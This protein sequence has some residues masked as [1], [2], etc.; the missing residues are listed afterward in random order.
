[1]RRRVVLG[2]EVDD[3]GAFDAGEFVPAEVGDLAAGRGGVEAGGD[4]EQAVDL[5]EAVGDDGGL[6]DEAEFAV[7]GLDP[8]GATLRPPA[9]MTRLFLRPVIRR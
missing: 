2:H 6:A 8:F 4:D 9:V 3:G 5:V 1:W 7:A